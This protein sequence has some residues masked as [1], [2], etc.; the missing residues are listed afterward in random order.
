[1]N[2][3]N[4]LADALKEAF[5]H[6]EDY[7]CVPVKLGHAAGWLCYLSSMTDSAFMTEHVMLPLVRYGRREEGQTTFDRMEDLKMTC[8]AALSPRW[9]NDRVKAVEDLSQGCAV[10]ILGDDE[11]GLILDVKK[12]S[13]RGIEEPTTQTVVK[14]PKEGFTESAQTNISLIRRRLLDKQLRTE[15]FTLGSRSRTPVYVVYLNGEADETVLRRLREELQHVKTEAMFDSGSLER[16]LQPK[17]LALFPTLYSSERPDAVCGSL[18]RGKIAIIVNGSPFVLIVP[19]LMNDFFKSPEDQ[20]QWF[21]FGVFT[22]ALRYLSFFI[23]LMLPS[24]YVAAINFQQ[25]LIPT[26][27][28]V[29]IAAQRESIP[30]PAAI[31]VLL[32]E[33]T[34]EIL[35]E[36]GTR[37]PRV[38]GQAISIV[39]ALVLGEAAVQAGIVSNIL[40][41][42]VALT[43]ISS[44]VSPVY[45]F[46]TNVRLL[47]FALIIMASLFGVFGVILGAAF[48]MIHLTRLHSFGVPYVRTLGEGDGS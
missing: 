2:R 22:R 19:A 37:M 1:M 21:A 3:T 40:V 25:E 43:A 38:V 24:L 34:F 15:K 47:R 11:R 33:G 26:T 20:Y 42:V 12:L 6:S 9:D 27:L 35:R 39:G 23:S 48:L 28:L 18:C 32:L 8:F 14:G 36:A 46:S 29:S 44:F 30:F 10:L 7:Q 45:S 4:R 16:H 17:G 13:A 41:I 31:E 5:G